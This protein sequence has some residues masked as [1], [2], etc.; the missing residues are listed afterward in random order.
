MTTTITVTIDTGKSTYAFAAEPSA[1]IPSGEQVAFVA[2]G[3]ASVPVTTSVTALP[4]GVVAVEGSGTLVTLSTAQL[5]PFTLSVAGF[6]GTPFLITPLFVLTLSVSDPRIDVEVGA[7]VAVV[8]PG[9]AQVD[10]TAPHKDSQP[11]FVGEGASVTLPASGVGTYTIA[12]GAEG[13]YEL[14]GP[15]QTTTPIKG[16]INVNTTRGPAEE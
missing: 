10:I 7:E 1:V 15:D 8:G 14:K 16:K 12:S 4:F 6:T 3:V 2:S 5:A 11:L 9:G 13:L